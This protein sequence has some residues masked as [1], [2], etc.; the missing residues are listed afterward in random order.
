M[1]TY[2]SLTIAM[3]LDTADVSAGANRA[4]AEQQRIAAETKRINSD[5]ATYRRALRQRGE[6]LKGRCG[7]CR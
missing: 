4:I 5:L 1:A 7:I 6:N 3:R 2:K